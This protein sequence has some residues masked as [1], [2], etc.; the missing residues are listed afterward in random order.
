MMNKGV[1]RRIANVMSYIKHRRSINMSFPVLLQVDSLTTGEGVFIG[2]R[3]KLIGDISHGRN[4]NIGPKSYLRGKICISDGTNIVSKGFIRGD[5]LIGKYCAIAEN[6]SFLERNHSLK[7]ASIQAMFF[8]HHF[9]TEMKTT[10]KG[11]IKCGS[12]IWIGKGS[13][14][15]SGVKIGHGAIIG[16]G[17]VVSKDVEPYSISAG[18]PS[19]HIRWRFSEN[20]RKQL[21]DINWW[22]WDED[23]IMAN[24]K[25]FITDLTTIDDIE[26]LI[27]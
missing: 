8:K 15:L 19:R 1:L 26:D 2:K 3:S 12:D 13:I 11:L 9:N 16:A 14:I 25:F 21:L 20:I 4:V 24:P 6:V 27:I 5:V 23:K 17:S 7:N 18:S 10:S 22:N